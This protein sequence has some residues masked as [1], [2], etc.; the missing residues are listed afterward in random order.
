[1][2]TSFRFRFN[3]VLALNV[4]LVVCFGL[5]SQVPMHLFLQDCKFLT[6]LSCF[7]F[8]L[9]FLTFMYVKYIGNPQSLLSLPLD[10]NAFQP[11]RR[12]S[13]MRLNDSRHVIYGTLKENSWAI[14]LFDLEI[15]LC[16]VNFNSNHNR[17]G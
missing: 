3:S 5:H 4:L 6:L 11:L 10:I 15:Y 2:K 7:P 12:S 1:M 17:Q 8:L 14:G 16:T 13:P 9:S